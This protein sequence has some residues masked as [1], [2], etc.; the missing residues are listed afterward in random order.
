MKGY[1]QI[2]AIDPGKSGGIASLL[3]NRKKNHVASVRAVKMPE[4]L[5]EI[6]K[7]LHWLIHEC[8]HD[9]HILY[10]EKLQMMPSD[11]EGFK[12]FRIAKMLK[13]YEQMIGAFKTSGF[14]YVEVTPR[15]WQGK[16]IAKPI[17]EKK[18]RKHTFQRIAGEKYPTV[19]NTLAVSDA[20]CILE[21][22]RQ[23][24]VVN[25]SLIVSGTR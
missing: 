15:K 25:P 21:Y 24:V 20:L 6:N 7:Y 4:T 12:A 10:I 16:F 8:I 11:L 2:L 1:V 13:G 19:K 22:G 18:E 9:G 3:Y 14:N 17:K 5:Q 23:E